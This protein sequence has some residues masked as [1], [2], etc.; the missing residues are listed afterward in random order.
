M[1]RALTRATVRRVGGVIER[2]RT[3]TF[4]LLVLGE[5]GSG[6]TWLLAAGMPIALCRPGRSSVGRGRAD[7]S[8]RLLTWRARGSGGPSSV[9][10]LR[11]VYASP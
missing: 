2:G 8:H 4:K 11:F 1:S 10:Y 3:T 9:P 7:P 5:A 6:N